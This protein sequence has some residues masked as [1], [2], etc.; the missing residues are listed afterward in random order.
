MINVYITCVDIKEAKK[1]SAHLL[2]KRLIACVHLF[3]IESMYR[4][5][6]K[7]QYAKEISI[8]A[9]TEKKHFAMIKK[10]VTRLHSYE[11]PLIEYWNSDGIN[12]PYLKWLKGELK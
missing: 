10:E 5:K 8:I 6:G 9:K 4:W 1:I 2:K 12:K 7:M 3:P 11:V